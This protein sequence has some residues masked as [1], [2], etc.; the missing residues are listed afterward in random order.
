M[1]AVALVFGQR[2][3]AQTIWSGLTKTFTKPSAGDPMLPENQDV[4][5][6]NVKLT[7]GSSG[8]LINIASEM[9]YNSSVS[10]ALTLW[11][12][13]LNSPGKTI[14]AT[15][16]QDLTFT[17]WIDAFGGS[18]SAGAY[19]ENRNA[20]VQLVSDNVYLDLRFTSWVSGAGGGFTYLRAEPPSSMPTGDYNGN[21]FVDASDYV[22]WRNTF[23]Q[24][25]VPAGTGADGNSNGEIDVLDYDFWRARFGNASSGA[26]TSSIMLVPEPSAILCA[27]FVC[28]IFGVARADTRRRYSERN[29]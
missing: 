18:H 10:P 27:T 6:S 1:F 25:G 11:A 20:V 19:I 23:G 2:A 14:A 4:L 22:V 17:N 28:S 26:G 3:A 9:F 15:S 7:R 12:T 24:T 16:F 21:G 8:G 5:T 13:D 29:F